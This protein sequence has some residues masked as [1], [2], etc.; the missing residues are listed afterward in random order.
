[1]LRNEQHCRWV[2]FTYLIVSLLRI[3]Y[4]LIIRQNEVTFTS[5]NNRTE[6]ELRGVTSFKLNTLDPSL[7]LAFSSS[8]WDSCWSGLSVC[9]VI[10]TALGAESP[11]EFSAL[12]RNT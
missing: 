6:V 4:I 5:Q 3:T 10:D 1:M 9:A 11:C 12:T 7:L 2:N 8:C